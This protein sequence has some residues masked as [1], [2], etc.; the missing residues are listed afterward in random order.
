MNSTERSIIRSTTPIVA[1]FV[2]TLLA[3]WGFHGFDSQI[4]AITTTV[5]AAGYSIGARYL[6]KYFPQLGFLLIVKGAPTY[7]PK[8]KP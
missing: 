8:T 4:A 1:G 3:R 7:P 5:I 2:I 6:E